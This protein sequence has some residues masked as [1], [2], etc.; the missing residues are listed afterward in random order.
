M[1]TFLALYR[2]TTIGDARMVAV[3]ADPE[4]VAAVATH[5]LDTP[6]PHDADPVI[7]ALQHGRRGALR[8]IH[9]ETTHAEG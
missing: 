2:G 5:L 6:Q 3:T 9:R 1:T 7:T 8:L 4:L